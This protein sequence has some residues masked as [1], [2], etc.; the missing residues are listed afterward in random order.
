MWL[1]E[2]GCNL[3]DF[4][5]LVEQ[6]TDL[7]DYPAAAGVEGNVV[8]YD[9][10]ELVA[11]AKGQQQRRQ[12]QSELGRALSDGPGIIAVK[13]AFDPTVVDRATEVFLALMDEESA[14]GRGHGDHFAKPGTNQR[15]WNSLSKLVLRAPE[16]AVDYLGNLV[17]DTVSV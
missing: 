17:V 16:V 6:P 15:L 5:A 3:E 7:H 11:H 14:S 8:I 12:L 4:R 10:P 9:G 13:S 2:A 1:T